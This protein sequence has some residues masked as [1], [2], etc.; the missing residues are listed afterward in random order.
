MLRWS[1]ISTQEHLG[2]VGHDS[3][4]PAQLLARAVHMRPL[5]DTSGRGR[6]DIAKVLN[7]RVRELARSGRCPSRRPL[8]EGAMAAGY[9]AYRFRVLRISC[10]SGRSA[11]AMNF[12]RLSMVFRIS[13]SEPRP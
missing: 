8:Q 6:A 13:A 3:H 12:C 11:A 7:S 4:D 10:A 1:P 5:D 9:G 2:H